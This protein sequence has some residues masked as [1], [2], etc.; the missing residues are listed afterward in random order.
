MSLGD[1][2]AFALTVWAVFVVSSFVRFVLDEEV[3]PR[4]R[5]PRGAAYAFATIVHYVIVVIGFVL[6]V[7]ALGIDLNRLTIVAGA[8]GLGVGIGLQSTVANFVSGLILLLERR[9]RAAPPR[10]RRRSAR[11][12]RGPD[13]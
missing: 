1:V 10:G 11:H 5:L 4:V 12:A 13:P 9:L 7:A 6:A 2:A 3:Y 8:L